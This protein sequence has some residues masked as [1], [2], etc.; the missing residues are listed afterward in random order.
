MQIPANF[1]R[2]RSSCQP[3]AQ[4][5]AAMTE[6]HRQL[7]E[8]LI[9]DPAMK[10]LVLTT[11]I[12]GSHRRGTSLLGTSAHP[13]DVD[14]IV[15]TGLSRSSTTARRASEVFQP[16]LSRHYA[17]RFSQR[18]RSWC[19][20]TS[21]EIRLDVVPMAK[22]DS[23]AAESALASAPLREWSPN[24]DPAASIGTAPTGFDWNRAEPLW[25][26]DRQLNQWEQTHAMLLLDWTRQKNDRCNGHFTA[27]VRAIKWWW[28][29]IQ[30]QPQYLKGYPLEHIVGECCPNSIT[31]AADGIALTFESIAGK[32]QPDAAAA[33]TPTLPA[34]GVPGINVLRRV[35]PREFAQFVKEASTAAPIARRAI[36]SGSASET[37]ELWV[38]LLGDA[39]R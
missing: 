20:T 25:I 37:M 22:P 7:R 30:P 23:S 9:G 19:I 18:L 14:I 38:R 2:F 26:P 36:N 5:F 8:R 27:V 35:D 16:F 32:F 29:R 17:G 12:Q 39:I 10:G 4:Q 15:V 11:L 28:R 34:R 24:P 33:R 21:P 31:S 1:E 6:E 13:C 3:T